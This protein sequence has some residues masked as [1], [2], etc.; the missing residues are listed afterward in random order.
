MTQLPAHSSSIPV[1]HTRGAPHVSVMNVSI[2]LSLNLC[3]HGL[4]SSLDIVSQKTKKK[5]SLSN[6]N[7]SKFEK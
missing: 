5:I 2:N 3:A 6:Q 1:V 7:E 4:E